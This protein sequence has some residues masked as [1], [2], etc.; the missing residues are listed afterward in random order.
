MKI[1]TTLS[2]SFLLGA[3]YLTAIVETGAGV[4]LLGLPSVTASLL[5]GAALE[6]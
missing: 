4:V 2:L 6:T 5:L 3:S 1:T